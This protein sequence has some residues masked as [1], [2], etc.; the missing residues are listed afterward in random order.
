MVAIAWF[1]SCGNQDTGVVDS[2]LDATWPGM[3]TDAIVP[4][5]EAFGAAADALSVGPDGAAAYTL[6]LATPAGRMGM[7]PDLALAYSSNAGN[8]LFG[9]GFTL[10]GGPSAITR[11]SPRDG[12]GTRVDFD[13]ASFCW[14]GERLVAVTGFTGRADGDTI[15]TPTTCVEYRTRNDSFARIYGLGKTDDPTAFRVE[16]RDGRILFFETR[17]EARQYESRDSRGIDAPVFVRPVT[18]EWALSR[19]ED[20]R[21]NSIIYR[22]ETDSGGNREPWLTHVLTEIQY[23]GFGDEAGN[24]AIRFLYEARPDVR[25]SFTAG[26]RLQMH[27]RVTAIEMYGPGP[28]G[29]VSLQWQY[30]LEY[31]NDSITGRSVIRQIQ[32]SDGTGPQA[33][34]EFGWARGSFAVENQDVRL[35]AGTEN[36][37]VDLDGDGRS[38]L[39]TQ[40]REVPSGHPSPLCTPHEWQVR[41]NTGR[42]GASMFGS[43]VCTGFHESPIAI[44]F[45]ADGAANLIAVSYRTGSVE[46]EVPPRFA[47]GSVSTFRTEPV[48]EASWRSYRW[49][50]QRMSMLQN[51]GGS[52]HPETSDRADSIYAGDFDGN[53]TTDLIR[54]DFLDS[55]FTMVGRDDAPTFSDRMARTFGL[56]GTSDRPESTYRRLFQITDVDGDGVS[57][58]LVPTPSP[59][60]TNALSYEAICF[61]TSTCASRPVPLSAHNGGLVDPSTFDRGNGANYRFMDVNGD[62]LD[63]VVDM[64]HSTIGRPPADGGLRIRFNT[65]NGYLPWQSGIESGFTY[66]SVAGGSTED[67]R[68]YVLD[69]NLD[70]LEDFITLGDAPRV[71][72]SNGTTFRP[73]NLPFSHDD[74]PSES[75]GLYAPLFRRPPFILADTDGN[76]VTDFL[77]G[78]SLREYRRTSAHPDRIISV[79][80]GIGARDRLDYAPVREVLLDRADGCQYPLGCGDLRMQVVSAIHRDTGVLSRLPTE[81]SELYSYGAPRIDAHRGA[82]L[83]FERVRR[84]IPIASRIEET[85]Y[86]SLRPSDV[87]W[88]ETNAGRQPHFGLARL[89][90]ETWS[91]VQT[92]DATLVEQTIRT[93]QEVRGAFPGT[94]ALQLS[95]VESKVH[96]GPTSAWNGGDSKKPIAVQ[97]S[98]VSSG[99]EWDNLENRQQT[100]TYSNWDHF[101]NPRQIATTTLGGRTEVVRYDFRRLPYAA[102]GTFEQAQAQPGF[103]S[104][105]PLPDRIDRWLIALPDRVSVTSSNRAGAG[106]DV[107]TRTTALYWNDYGELMGTVR[108]PLVPLGDPESLQLSTHFFRDTYGN[109]THVQ[110]IDHVDATDQVSQE[111]VSKYGYDEDST[112]LRWARNTAGHLSWIGIH[113]SLAVPLI[114]VDANGAETRWRYDGYGRLRE[115]MGA[116]G[117]GAVFTHT[118]G[119]PA[120]ITVASRGGGSQVMQ[121]DRLNRAVQITSTGLGGIA[122]ESS[123]VFDRLGHVAVERRGRM[124]AIPARVVRPEQDVLGRVTALHVEPREGSTPQLVWRTN[125]NAPDLRTVTSTDADGESRTLVTDYDGLPVSSREQDDEGVVLTTAYRLGPFGELQSSSDAGANETIY[126]RDAL[127]RP[128]VIESP[129]R[130]VRILQYNAW[131]ELV[132]TEDDEQG[133]ITYVRDELGRVTERRHARGVTTYIW[134]I[135]EHGLGGLSTAIGEDGHSI[136]VLYDTL[137]RPRDVSYSIAG[138]EYVVSYD[139]D[140]FGRL[141]RVWYPAA[142]GD[143]LCIQYAYDR[144]SGLLNKVFT[145]SGEVFWELLEHDGDGHPTV[146]QAGRNRVERE[147]DGVYGVQRALRVRNGAALLMAL[148]TTLYPDGMLATREDEVSGRHET[149]NYDTLDRIQWYHVQNRDGDSRATDYRYSPD[150]NIELVTTTLSTRSAALPPV[151]EEYEYDRTN[152]GGPHAVS[153]ITTRTHGSATTAAYSY[154][155]IGRQISAPGRLITYTVADLPRKISAG[156]RGTSFEYDAFDSRALTRTNEFTTHHVGSLFERRDHRT[157]R[158]INTFYVFGPSGLIAIVTEPDGGARQTNYQHADHLGT[159]T[160]ITDASGALV[161]SQFFDPFGRRLN[162]RLRDAPPGPAPEG[163]GR[164][165]FTGHRDEGE[166][167]LVDM[168]GRF[169]DPIARRFLTP[170]PFVS[171]PSSSQAWNPYSWVANLGPNATDPS[172]LCTVV[173]DHGD[174][175]SVTTDFPGPCLD[176]VIRG[177]TDSRLLDLNGDPLGSSSPQWRPTERDRELQAEAVGAPASGMAEH[178]VPSQGTAG[179]TPR[180][181]IRDGWGPPAPLAIEAR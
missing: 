128:S 140:S 163:T 174:G 46:I 162:A 126:T 161:S 151:V 180:S 23:T 37:A 6:P 127:G 92:G 71:Y 176:D 61:E 53:G 48:T 82:F 55:W 132:S 76:G 135:E 167:D 5:T 13:R 56:A 90:T 40:P 2:E 34:T 81:R 65:G 24:R 58:F 131:N 124:G 18:L 47:N 42:R 107:E 164:R 121:L 122:V 68:T 156:H 145:K 153:A 44:D 39:L 100:T 96:S 150:G 178:R 130:G 91:V 63:D 31:T 3:P 157:E 85:I 170:D 45:D 143:R 1:A 14:N 83:A 154:D 98:A 15:C 119:P 50:N 41:M 26:V 75:A 17:V 36:L 22:Y 160:L 28:R 137:G 32:R 30:S 152:G 108:E 33:P 35:P 86:G 177:D 9:V 74:K 123:R 141:E 38:D 73:Q 113:P 110:E 105:V 67:T 106:A 169:Y 8:G 77:V 115:Q 120:S 158:D 95:S 87:Q 97:L 11:C 103:E 89:P 19:E 59:Y 64:Q 79:R 142:N 16:T 84:A 155:R 29:S 175:T 133:V 136:R 149:Y 166:L 52:V 109:I 60:G 139:H 172:G 54:R 10:T 104:A 179:T 111:R 138:T 148:R 27:Q 88:I 43:P 181:T 72:V 147:Y 78:E 62:G 12:A 70:G 94:F 49:S 21:G 165:G 57:D 116:D 171:Q 125:Y 146:V 102:A 25:D 114:H 134:D 144:R 80:R 129:D 4:S 66:V 118:S 93:Y 51:L 7:Q 112:H 101:G 69:Y 117:S 20:R 173:F 168:R 159:A 99:G